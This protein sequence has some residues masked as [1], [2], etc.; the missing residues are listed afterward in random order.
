MEEETKRNKFKQIF[1]KKRLG[2]LGIII[3]ILLSVL[4]GGGSVYFVMNKQV[5][6]LQKENQSLGKISSVFNTIYYN[7]YK[8]VSQ[9]K[10]TNGAISGM[11]NALG[12]PFSEYMSAT[13]SSDLNDT[14][15]GNFGGIGAQVEKSDHAVKII[16][17]IAETPAAKAGLKA[18][19]LIIKI[20]NKSTSSM[21]LTKAVQSMRG[22]VGTKVTVTIK[23]NGQTFTKTLTRAK[24]PV[25]TVTGQLSSQNKSVGVITVTSFATNT[26]KE[27]KQTI[28]SLRKQGAK[29]FVIDMRNNPGGLMDQALKMSS[30]FVKN[31]KIILQV[32]T[33]GGKPTV[34][35]AGKQYDK[36]FKVHE[37]TVVL[38]N[39]GS[40]SAAEIFSAALHQSAGIK[41]IGTKSYGKGTV[42]STLPYKDKTELKLTIAKWLT[43]DGTWIHHKGLTPDITADYPKIAYTIIPSTT[44]TLKLNDNSSSVKSL[45]KMLNYLGFNAGSANG[46]FSTQTQKAVL[47]YQKQHGLTQNGSADAKILS[48][49]ESE[50]S[51]K[52]SQQDNAMTQALK[53]VK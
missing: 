42:Q 12:D 29:S 13:E 47:S 9:K 28:K 7:Y 40:A 36:G 25:K 26:S 43:P 33:R 51:Q 15:S 38:I 19:D 46:Y 53:A 35:R 10:L 39:S 30:M 37:K 3:T 1:Q 34:Y 23:R 45:Q 2:L 27:M 50:I 31:G 22:K 8:N 44:K 4:V 6:A 11:I 18:N 5:T 14:I 52:V 17:P 21:T 32:Q 16:A 48:Q 41:L 24:I 49:I 20:N